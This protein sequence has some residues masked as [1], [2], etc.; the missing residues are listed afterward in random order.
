MSIS[1]DFS[2]NS[3]T[4]PHYHMKPGEHMCGVPVAWVVEIEFEGGC[5]VKREV[6]ELRPGRS[7]QGFHLLPCGLVLG[8]LGD[9]SP[10]VDLQD[11]DRVF[12]AIEVDRGFEVHIIE[13]DDGSQG[14]Q[15]DDFWAP[16]STRTLLFC[17]AFS[18]QEQAVAWNPFT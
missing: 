5:L 14:D 6:I 11:D 16:R 1:I 2:Q 8:M 12:C 15:E 9:M 3:G 18:K 4:L 10:T 17:M 13:C 7:A